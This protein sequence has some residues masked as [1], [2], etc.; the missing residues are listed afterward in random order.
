MIDGG[1]KVRGVMV[2]PCG[3]QGD[4]GGPPARGGRE[5]AGVTMRGQAQRFNVLLGSIFTLVIY[6]TEPGHILHTQVVEISY[7]LTVQSIAQ[8]RAQ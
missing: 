5:L 6:V 2:Q 8:Y 7:S 4:A 1:S 3:L